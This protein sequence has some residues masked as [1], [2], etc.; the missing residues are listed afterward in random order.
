MARISGNSS[1]RTSLPFLTAPA[2]V[3]LLA[4]AG[5]HL[6]ESGIALPDRSGLLNPHVTQVR[7]SRS[8]NPLLEEPSPVKYAGDIEA[9][10]LL[11]DGTTNAQTTEFA[12]ALR[13]ADRDV[14]LVEYDHVDQRFGPAPYRIDML[15]RIDDFLRTGIGVAH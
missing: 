14:V 13:R 7:G 9:S 11:F 10:T 6:V 2:R 8:M 4:L 12:G 5:K 1:P 3:S 15:V